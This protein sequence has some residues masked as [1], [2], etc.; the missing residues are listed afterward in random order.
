MV[1]LSVLLNFLKIKT[2]GVINRQAVR[3]IIKKVK[4]ADLTS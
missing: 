1:S 4:P 3:L 2:A